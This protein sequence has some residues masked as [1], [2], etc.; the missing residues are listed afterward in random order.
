MAKI[1]LPKGFPKKELTKED[2]ELD[3]KIIIMSILE[4]LTKT[5][6]KDDVDLVKLKKRMNEYKN[7]RS[8]INVTPKQR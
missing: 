1:N 3:E 2:I 7:R 5:L 6:P 4:K 8:E